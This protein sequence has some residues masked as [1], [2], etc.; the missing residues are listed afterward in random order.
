MTQPPSP[1]PGHRERSLTLIDEVRF[2]MVRRHGYEVDDVD[3]WLD[4][5]RIDVAEDRPID[6]EKLR[7]TYF[8]VSRGRGYDAIAVDDFIDSLIVAQPGESP[9][10]DFTDRPGVARLIEEIENV[11]FAIDRH[12]G[13]D[14]RGVEIWLGELPEILADDDPELLQMTLTEGFQVTNKNGYAAEEVDRFV[15]HLTVSL[16]GRMPPPRPVDPEPETPS[17]VEG[18]MT[19]LGRLFSRG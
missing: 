10:G 2:R 4:R 18:L 12:G 14:P 17:G 8:R 15:D 1:T 19:K 6:A 13:Y 7:N 3:S 16:T 5:L 11:R 9:H